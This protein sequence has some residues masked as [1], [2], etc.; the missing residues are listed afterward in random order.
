MRSSVVCEELNARPIDGSA[1]LATDRLRLATPATA[2]SATSTTPLRA[3]DDGRPG[4][5]SRPI[6][7]VGAP[8]IVAGEPVPAVPGRCA[9]SDLTCALVLSSFATVGTS[10]LGRASS[11]LSRQPFRHHPAWMNRRGRAH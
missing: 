10:L 6:P 2:I 3:G 8:L 4:G 7:A 9:A 1:T 11:V 5:S